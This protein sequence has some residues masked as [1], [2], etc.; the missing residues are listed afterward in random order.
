MGVPP[1]WSML[2]PLLNNL[3]VFGVTFWCICCYYKHAKRVDCT[4]HEK[5]V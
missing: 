1:V 3:A 5:E 4:V 2:G